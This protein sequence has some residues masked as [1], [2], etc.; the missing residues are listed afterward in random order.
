[1]VLGSLPF[2]LDFW[3]AWVKGP[4]ADPYPDP[5]TISSAICSPASLTQLW[6]L[7][8]SMSQMTPC[9]Q[10]QCY[11]SVLITLAV[12][13][14]AD[15]A[16]LLESHSFNL[17]L[18]LYLFRFFLGFL[19][20]PSLECLHSAGFWAVLTSVSLPLLYLHSS[21]GELYSHWMCPLWSLLVTSNFSLK[22]RSL[23]GALHPCLTICS[24]FPLIQALLPRNCWSPVL[25]I[26][27][28][29]AI[30]S[31]AK[32][33]TRILSPGSSAFIYRQH[34]IGRQDL[35]IPWPPVPTAVSSLK[36]S[37]SFHWN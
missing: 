10:I 33:G 26:H 4:L 12:F 15:H 18:V 7:F 36:T 8:W 14:T 30:R 25:P 28:W 6:S 32:L 2:Q 34:H 17:C 35:S 24:H 23:S 5:L 27:Y 9:C 37:I 16:L 11:V 21:P 20:L 1:M 3:K 29:S 22:C 19:F 31:A 13:A